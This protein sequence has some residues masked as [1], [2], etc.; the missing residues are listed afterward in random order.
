MLGH[1][2]AMHLFNKLHTD[3]RCSLWINRVRISEGWAMEAGVSISTGEILATSQCDFLSLFSES[4]SS[5]V[6]FLGSGAP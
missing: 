3:F 4:A 1:T 2:F 6:I 5:S